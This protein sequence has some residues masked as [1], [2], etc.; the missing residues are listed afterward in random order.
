MGA[1]E[2]LLTADTRRA[3]AQFDTLGMKHPD[4]SQPRPM[5][6]SYQ[7]EGGRFLSRN[8]LNH[9]P[10]RE[11]VFLIRA[12]MGTSTFAYVDGSTTEADRF[13]GLAMCAPGH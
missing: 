2:G 3:L 10:I 7:R 4:K 8:C 5:S 13:I 9:R 11:P 12:A 6:V 1:A